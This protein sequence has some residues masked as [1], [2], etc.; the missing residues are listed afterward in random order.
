MNILNSKRPDTTTQKVSVFISS[1]PGRSKDSAGVSFS[2]LPSFLENKRKKL[3]LSIKA[4]S[5]KTTFPF[6]YVSMS[7]KGTIVPSLTYL[8]IFCKEINCPFQ[9]TA[10]LE[11]SKQQIE[12]F[13]RTGKDY[14]LPRHNK[15]SGVRDKARTSFPISIPVQS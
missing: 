4:V 15:P 3:N 9:K 13:L 6:L 12:N 8:L 2:S 7:E 14:N 10:E 1:N 5:R 11:Y